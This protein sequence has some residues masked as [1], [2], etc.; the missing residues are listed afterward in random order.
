M[1]APWMA[2]IL[3]TILVPTVPAWSSGV[4]A[5]GAMDTIMNSVTASLFK[6]RD[7]HS[8]YT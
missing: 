4:A 5:K 1:G 2:G 7:R 3:S 8:K 6:N